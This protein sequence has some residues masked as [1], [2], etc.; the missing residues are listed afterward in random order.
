M[1]RE[2]CL[3]ILEEHDVGPNMRRLIHHF[4]D[5][6]MNCAKPW[7]TTACLSRHVAEGGPLSAKL[8]NNMVD[9]VVR[10]WMQLLQEEIDLEGEEL[11]EIMDT[12]FTIFY[13][14]NAYIASRNLVFVQKGIDG[15]V[16]TFKRFG[17]ET[18]TKKTQAMT[19]T[20]GNIRLQ[21][22]TE[23]Y[24]PMRTGRTPAPNWDA[25][26]VICRE[27]RKRMQERNADELSQTPPCGS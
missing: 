24:Q 22:P 27:C 3:L 16:T 17:L 10:E 15:L 19:C 5:E 20:P 6:A 7:G 12:L 4:W 11:D 8:F 23:S 21:L 9:A 18:N 13:V 14:D 25:C 26:T 2:R 1:D